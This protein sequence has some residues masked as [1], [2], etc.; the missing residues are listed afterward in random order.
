MQK[1]NEKIKNE[2]PQNGIIIKAEGTTT[3]I[4]MKGYGG[5]GGVPPR[6]PGS[7][8]R[9]RRPLS[10]VYGLMSHCID[11]FH[12]VFYLYAFYLMAAASCRQPQ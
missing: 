2:S 8:P 5:G 3:R 9:R 10:F 7:Q 6:P 12:F 4:Q 11:R 1:M